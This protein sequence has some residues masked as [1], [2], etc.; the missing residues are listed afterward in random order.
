MNDDI[1]IEFLFSWRV[2]SILK[3][4]KNVIQWL[5]CQNP[6]PIK[7]IECSCNLSLQQSLLPN[8]VQSSIMLSLKIF[9][10]GSK[11]KDKAW[12]QT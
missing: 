6:Y 2:W 10:E 4:N 12:L 8:F 5:I 9:S 7:K 1:I 11:F 3:K